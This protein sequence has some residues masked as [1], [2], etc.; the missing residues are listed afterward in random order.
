MKRSKFRITTCLTLACAGF[1]FSLA[2]CAQAQTINYIAIFDGT[3]GEQPSSVIQAT[4]GN[5]YGTT[6]FG[7][8]ALHGNV[9]K[10]TPTGELSTLYDFC[11]RPHCLDGANP[12]T[13]PILGSDGNLYGVT[14]MGG[15]D[16]NGGAGWGTV[17]KLTLDGHLTT[18][19]AFCTGDL[20]CLDG[21]DPDGLMQAADGTLYGTAFEGGQFDGGTLFKLTAAGKFSLVHTFCSSANCADGQWPE[22]A[23]IQGSDGNL[24]GVTPLGGKA[25]AG[26]L[27]DLTPAGRFNV[28][29]T[30]LCFGT[31][32]NLGGSPN[33][34]MQ[35]AAGNLF[36]ATGGGGA[37][38]EGTIFEITSN[39]QYLN[40][41]TFSEFSPGSLTR[42]N[43][44]NFYGTFGGINGAG[45]IFQFTPSGTLTTLYTFTCCAAGS[46]PSSGLSQAP[47]GNFYGSVQLYNDQWNGAVYSFDNNLSPLVQTVPTMGK[48]SKQIHILGNGLTGTTRVAFNGVSARFTVVS[49]TYIKATVPAGATTGIVSVVTPSGTLNSNPQFVVTK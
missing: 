19:Y 22:H 24:Y 7:G 27:Y 42:A 13:P 15:S 26:V 34:V 11:S 41:F 49:D 44:G 31:S 3:N 33:S 35:D 18:L 1:T 5:F 10:I 28:V 37:F 6:T 38:G 36:G 12:Y 40:L 29:H 47:N 45:G 14:A 43:D 32:C 2:L 4:D 25:D 16:A 8:P 17:Y 9:V 39:H 21:L 48:V 30:F 46:A 23:P 20:P